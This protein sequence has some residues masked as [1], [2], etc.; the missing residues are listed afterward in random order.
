MQKPD[1]TVLRIVK[2]QNRIQLSLEWSRTGSSVLI[3]VLKQ[4]YNSYD[5]GKT[6]DLYYKCVNFQIFYKQDHTGKDG[7]KEEGKLVCE[8]VSVSILSVL[9]YPLKHWSPTFLAP[10]T[11]F[12]EEN[13][14]M[15]QEREGDSLGMIQ[16]Q[17]CL[18][19]YNPTTGLTEGRAQEVIG[20][21]EGSC[22]YR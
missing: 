12:M 3:K 16:G 9:S 19:S 4:N 11:N 21:S 7:T 18:H 15:G 10:G 6:N 1:H 14:S 17:Q 5:Q 2:E 22:K 20:V 8:C 13:F